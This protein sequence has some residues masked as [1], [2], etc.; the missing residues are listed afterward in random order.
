MEK[1]KKIKYFG[2]I[3]AITPSTIISFN[4]P[5]LVIKIYLLILQKTTKV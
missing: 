3:A 1:D 4:E 5:F 2:M